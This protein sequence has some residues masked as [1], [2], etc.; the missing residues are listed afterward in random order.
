MLEC[1]CTGW[2][3][4]HADYTRHGGILTPENAINFW[5]PSRSISWAGGRQKSKEKK[6]KKGTCH[7]QT[8]SRI[9]PQEWQV[10]L[11][12]QLKM[13]VRL[14]S[15]ETKRLREKKQKST[16]KKEWWWLIY[17]R[18][19]D[20]DI[21]RDS[22]ASAKMDGSRARRLVRQPTL[23]YQEDS[24]MSHTPSL[25]SFLIKPCT[26]GNPYWLQVLHGIQSCVTWRCDWTKQPTTTNDKKYIASEK[27]ND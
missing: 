6:R 15:K 11:Y 3:S 9:E 1:G 27:R 22:R 12:S 14:S 5:P 25:Y 16:M 7:R 26:S 20:E 21:E 17:S 13:L 18:L 19:R 8:G 24:S 10:S 2:S 23:R 4:L